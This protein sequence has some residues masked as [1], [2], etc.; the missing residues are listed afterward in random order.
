MATRRVLNLE[1]AR[2]V[3]PPEALTSTDGVIFSASYDPVVDATVLPYGLESGGVITATGE[4]SEIH[5]ATATA[6]MADSA[7][8]DANGRVTAASA[9]FSLTRPAGTD[10]RFAAVIINAAGEFAVEYGTDAAEWVET[11]GTA[12]GPP[13]IPVTAVLVGLVKLD[14]TTPEPV[15][16]NDILQFPAAAFISQERWDFPQWVEPAFNFGKTVNGEVEFRSEVPMIHA[17]T[18]PKRVILRGSLPV[19]QRIANVSSFTPAEISVSS[20]STDTFDGPI[21]SQSQS[22]SDGSFE[23]ARM[24]DGVRDAVVQVAGTTRLVQFMPDELNPDVFI[25]T[26]GVIA[27]SRSFEGQQAATVSVTIAATGASVNVGA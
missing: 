19:F 16:I 13:L 21:A 23:L 27:P 4:D 6:L 10:K 5:V 11:Y 1:T 25:W 12:G 7:E 22:V 26:Q 17:G 8:A 9:T 3:Q 14:G 15:G 18:T 20:S 2:T 24:L